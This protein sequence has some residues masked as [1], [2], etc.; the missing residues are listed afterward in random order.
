MLIFGSFRGQ[1]LTLHIP[2]GQTVHELKEKIK[3]MLGI[4]GDLYRQDKKVLALNYAGS[5][6]GDS[7]VF[8]DLGLLP[9][10]NIK[11]KL[12][13]EVKPVLYIKCSHSQETLSVYEDMSITQM[14]MD[15]IRSIASTKS[16]L[17]VGIFRLTTLDGREMFDSQRLEDYGVDIGH[18]ILLE[19]WD[20][21]NEF[22]NLTVMGFT[23]QVM[24]QV[25]GDEVVAR[26]QMKV[27]LYISS[28]FGHVGLARCLLKQGCRSDEPTGY[29][30]ARTWCKQ[31]GHKD[32]LKCPVHE[33][34]LCGQLVVLKLFVLHD[35]TCLKAKDGNGLEPINLTLRNKI[36]NCASFLMSK[37]WSKVSITKTFS[38]RLGTYTQLRRWCDR[39]KE[40]AY[41]RH[42]VSKSSLK[43]RSFQSGPLV[44]HGIFVD[45]FSRSP[46]NGRTKASLQKEERDAREQRKTAVLNDESTTT[47]KADPESYFKALAAVQNFKANQR[48]PAKFPKRWGKMVENNKAGV[49]DVSEPSGF[50]KNTK[51]TRPYQEPTPTGNFITK[52]RCDE[53]K[54]PDISSKSVRMSGSHHSS[55]SGELAEAVQ[56]N[57]ELSQN[58]NKGAVRLTKSSKN[59][60]F[61]SSSQPRG[62]LKTS[63]IPQSSPDGSGAY[64]LDAR[65]SISSDINGEQQRTWAS[66]VAPSLTSSSDQIEDVVTED[67]KKSRKSR[68]RKRQGRMSSAVLLS[69]SR[70]SEGSIPLPLISGEQARRPFF[71]HRGQRE[72]GLVESTLELVSKYRGDTSR[73]R[74]IKS[75]TLA[76][77]FSRKPWLDQVRMAL[78]LTSK[79]LRRSMPSLGEPRVGLTA[80]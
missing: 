48:A 19:N 36:K 77:T 7:W 25:G 74:A 43:R 67:A 28:H 8:S 3:E 15:Q 52:S 73:E 59:A 46:M 75:L 4:S 18:T 10:T 57:R 64:K 51:N 6:L 40:R 17:P 47:G 54:L 13:E 32:S 61:M 53:T 45:G 14:K 69:K 50:S 37:Q 1:R 16:G 9:G 26:F 63:Q 62:S 11:I 80:H 5:D 12:K 41:L 38:V 2:I 20:G 44:S 72:D 68:P 27:A 23:P 24:S 79:S 29:H 66:N 58:A 34:A 55:F 71:Y 56:F 65:A 42:G 35:I 78:S 33:A 70:S 49:R 31:N 39:A 21:W 30:P 60:F 76:N 22:L